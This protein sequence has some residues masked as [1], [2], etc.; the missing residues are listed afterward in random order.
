VP[1]V[2]PADLAYYLQSAGGIVCRSVK[3]LGSVRLSL[4]AYNNAA[5]LDRV[6]EFTERAVKDGIP[7]DIIAAAHGAVA[8]P[9]A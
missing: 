4:H 5:D 9:D 1:G 7:A 6:A 3:Q 8:V 2:D